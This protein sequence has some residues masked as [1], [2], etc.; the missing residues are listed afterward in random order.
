MGVITE[1]RNRG[2]GVQPIRPNTRG[3]A[4]ANAADE[5]LLDGS[6]ASATMRGRRARSAPD[7]RPTG[8]GG[9]STSIGFIGGDEPVLP[10]IYEGTTPLEREK[11]PR[12]ATISP[13]T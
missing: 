11:T 2:A 5:R 9:F 12:R 4:G 10:A 7:A 8:G 1:F 13:R 6:S 3:A